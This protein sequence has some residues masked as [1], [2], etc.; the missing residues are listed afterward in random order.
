MHKA[1]KALADGIVQQACEDFVSCHLKLLGIKRVKKEDLDGKVTYIYRRYTKLCEEKKVA[2]KRIIVDCVSF[3]RSKWFE[4][5]KPD[6][7]GEKLMMTLTRHVQHTIKEFEEQEAAKEKSK[8][9]K[10]NLLW[11]GNTAGIGAN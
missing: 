4:Y 5:L 11:D 7:D 2:A 8:K 3:F 1:Y 9:T 6:L 10:T